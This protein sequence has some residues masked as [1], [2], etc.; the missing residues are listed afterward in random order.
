MVVIALLVMCGVAEANV[1]QWDQTTYQTYTDKTHVKFK[2]INKFPQ[3]AAYYVRIDEKRFPQKLILERNES[4]E[5]DITVDTPA[6][7]TSTKLVCTLAI[8]D[9]P[10][11]Y[12]VCTRLKFKRY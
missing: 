11:D 5:L 8:V 7:R 10:N 12:E 9:G 3:T 4:K 2:V 6:G 1:H